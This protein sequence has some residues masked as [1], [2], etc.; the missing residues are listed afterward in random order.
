MGETKMKES[1]TFQFTK[2]VEF[3]KR[4]KYH[5][6]IKTSNID[7]INLFVEKFRDNKLFPV[8]DR[9]RERGE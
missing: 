5:V 6:V 9:E 7:H 4:L 8:S 3:G 2:D 1:E